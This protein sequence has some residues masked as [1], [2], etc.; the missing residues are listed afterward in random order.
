MQV[1]Q[2]MYRTLCTALVLLAAACAKSDDKTAGADSATRAG[3]HAVAQTDSADSAAVCAAHGAPVALCFICD[4]SLREKGRLWCNEHARYEDRCWLCHPELRDA[5]RL[6]CEEHFLYEDECFLCHPE[7]RASGEVPAEHGMAGA[8]MCVEHAVAES[9]CGICHPE[10][11]AALG[12]GQ[13]LKVRLPSM[14]SAMKA[15]VAAEPIGTSSQGEALAATGEL[16]YNQNRLAR[17]TTPVD[18][19]VKNVQSDVGQAVKTGTSLLA[20]SSPRVAEVRAELIR[21]L[22]E[23]S[24]AAQSLKRQQQLFDQKVSA[25]RE[26]DDAR[27]RHESARALTQSARQTL[28]DLGLTVEDIERLAQ[29]QANESLLPLRAPFAGTVVER[30]VALG[31][32]VEAGDVMFV[33]ADLDMMWLKLSVTEAEAARLR[34]GDRVDARLESLGRDVS[35]RIT[36]I[37]S[38]LDQATRTVQVRAEIPNPEHRLRAGTFVTARIAVSDDRSQ[39][40][41]DRDAVHQIDG[42]N[43]VFVRLSDDLFELRAIDARPASG[44]RVAVHAGLSAGDV[45]V[46]KQSYLVKSEFQKSRLGAGCVD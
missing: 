17:I 15:G 7:L 21:A 44:D 11:A 30:T 10:L 19:V 22:S 12:P 45:V 5:T 43:F 36:W 42:H 29:N 23:E 27:S 20:V 38:G 40:S 31:D 39:M 41:I 32:V 4:A 24:V 8:L 34:V 18:G 3:S 33:V 46:T 16:G 13:G 6:Y 25:Q 37:S 9:E 14:T 35:G 2:L 1:K 28:R 26:L